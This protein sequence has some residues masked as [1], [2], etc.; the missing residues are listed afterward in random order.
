MNESAQIQIQLLEFLR[1]EV[2]SAQAVISEDSDLIAFGFDSLSMVRL[3]QFIEA[4]YGLWIPEGEI[5]EAAFKSTRA[6]AAVV[7]RLL[8]ERQTPS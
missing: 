8:D 1:R 2:F 3:L 4:T 6:L 7:V 5:T